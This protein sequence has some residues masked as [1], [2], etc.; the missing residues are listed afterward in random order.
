MVSASKILATSTAWAFCCA[1]SCPL[2][3]IAIKKSRKKA[4]FLKGGLTNFICLVV[5]S[6]RA[7]ILI[8]AENYNFF[9]VIPAMHNRCMIW[10]YAYLCRH[11]RKGKNEEGQDY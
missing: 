1:A 10:L 3:Q 6:G 11:G 8:K 7:G 4:I 9:L 5:L 2:P